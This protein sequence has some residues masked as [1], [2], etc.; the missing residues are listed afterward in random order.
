[1]TKNQKHH[2]I[3]YGEI[4]ITIADVANDVAFCLHFSYLVSDHRHQ[5]NIAD[6]FLSCDGEVSAERENYVTVTVS[7]IRPGIGSF[8]QSNDN[9]KEL[10]LRALFLQKLLM[11]T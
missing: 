4:N 5:K 11:I 1:M 2:G 6:H 8:F 3:K 9:D 7:L 10:Y